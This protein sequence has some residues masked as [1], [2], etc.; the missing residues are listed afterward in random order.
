MRQRVQLALA[1]LFWALLVGFVSVSLA[2]EEE[3]QDA[4]EAVT[5]ADAE[6]PFE[7]LALLLKPLTKDELLVEADGWQAL[8]QG[9]AEEIAKAEIAV[10]RQNREI[11]KAQGIQD[12]ADAPQEHIEEVQEK[13]Q[14]AK[15]TGDMEFGIGYEGDYAEDEPV[16]QKLAGLTKVKPDSGDANPQPCELEEN[17]Q[18]SSEGLS[19][20]ASPLA[21]GWSR[22]AGK[23]VISTNTLPKDGIAGARGSVFRSSFKSYARFPPRGNGV[24]N[25]R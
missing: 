10:Q 5:T 24:L 12:K 8:L 22:P 4:P 1:A 6:I 21:A 18:G 7:E 2:A 16:K 9:K 13:A 25:S 15:A 11:E 14:A 23:V 3:A 19:P 17:K 20:K